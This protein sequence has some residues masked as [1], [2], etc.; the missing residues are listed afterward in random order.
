MGNVWYLDSGA[1]FHMTR[2]KEFFSDLEDKDIHMDIEMG[3]DGR[4]SVTDIG[5]INFQRYS[6]SSLTLKYV[7]CVS[8]LKKVF[9]SVSILEDHDTMGYLEKERISFIT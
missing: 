5:T 8:C 1:S 6:S 7:M 3:D 4:Y 2:N 9:V